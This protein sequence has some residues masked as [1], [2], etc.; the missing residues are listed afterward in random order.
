MTAIDLVNY[1]T[2]EAVKLIKDEDYFNRNRHMF[3]GFNASDC[4]YHSAAI[5][6]AFLNQVAGTQGIDLGM[7]LENMIEKVEKED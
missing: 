7:Y 2:K 4:K 1:L 6:T 3:Q 5:M